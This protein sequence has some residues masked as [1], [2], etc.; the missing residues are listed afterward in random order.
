ME[1]VNMSEA[2]LICMLK[3][4]LTDLYE[5]QAD[6]EQGKVLTHKIKVIENKLRGLKV[7]DFN[8]LKPEP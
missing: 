1:G 3:D 8:E 7:T 5:I 2:E 4:F 6:K